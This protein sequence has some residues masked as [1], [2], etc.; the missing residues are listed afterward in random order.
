[1]ATTP[2][3][4]LQHVSVAFARPILSDL[5]LDVAHGET[6]AVVGESGTGK[7]TL[8]RL[9][10]GL[11]LPDRGT[12]RVMG[13]DIATL[14]AAERRA[15]RAQVG[16]VFQGAALFDSLSTFENVAF[17]LRERG[18][19]PERD[20]RARVNETLT[21]VDLDPAEVS[22]VLPA[23]LSGGMRKRV[24]IARALAARPALLLYDEPTAGLDPL[25]SETV[26]ALMQR[27]QQELR[28][29]SIVVSHDVRAMLR[30]ADRIALLHDARFAFL[31]APDAMRASEESY[32]QSFLAVA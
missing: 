4:E 31:G 25:T 16:M 24:G 23:Q 11:Q 2:A 5:S 8:L 6:V 13:R 26:T 15:L 18:D 10:L 19:M 7:S 28:V 17:A 21:L 14:D 32:T 20:V 27:L 22:Q 29:T 12:V 1:M 30:I 3:V 9:V